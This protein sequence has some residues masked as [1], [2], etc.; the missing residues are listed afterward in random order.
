MSHKPVA[1]TARRPFVILTLAG[2][3]CSLLLLGVG[4][5]QPD[6]ATLIGMVG[7][8]IDDLDARHT[9]DAAELAE[10]RRE[11]RESRDQIAALREQVTG[12]KGDLTQIKSMLGSLVR[13]TA[14]AAAPTIAI[15]E[16][17]MTSPDAMLEGVRSRYAKAFAGVVANNETA[18][19]D[20][21]KEIERWCRDVNHELRGKARWLTRIDA[22]APADASAPRDAAFIVTYTVLDATSRAAI[23]TSQSVPVPSHIGNKLKEHPAGTLA[24]VGVFFSAAVTFDETRVEAGI[25]GTPVMVGPH[26]VHGVTLEWTSVEPIRGS[27]RPERPPTDPAR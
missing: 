9:K 10:A 4:P 26:V 21:L 8:K 17:P 25:F 16:D 11:I 15:S 22:V 20:R 14:S 12:L 3:A 1:A 19:R 27:S 18:R 6:M 13:P 23:S 2:A 24:E 5:S 7:K